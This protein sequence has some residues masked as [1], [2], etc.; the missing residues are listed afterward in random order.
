MT[1]QMACKGAATNAA[2]MGHE[3]AEKCRAC[4]MMVRHDLTAHSFFGF[5]AGCSQAATECNCIKIK[6]PF[7]HCCKAM[8]MV[9]DGEC[10]AGLYE[11]E[12][13]S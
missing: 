5:A 7:G 3:H 6:V 12:G 10:S 13:E 8:H 4:G 11:V 2:R 9:P 1:A